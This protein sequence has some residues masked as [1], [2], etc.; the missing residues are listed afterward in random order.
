MSLSKTF[1]A[2]GIAIVFA[3]FIAYGISVIYEPPPYGYSDSDC[4]LKYNCDKAIRECEKQYLPNT[5]TPGWLCRYQNRTT[6]T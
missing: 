5:T 6:A 2:L 3:A 1:L 4:Y